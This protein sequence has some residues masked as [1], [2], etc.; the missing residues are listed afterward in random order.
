MDPLLNTAP[1]AFVSFADDGT[2]VEVNQTLADLLGY[3]RFE[4]EGWH[5]DKLL[6]PGGR[7]F[8]HTYLFPMLKMHALVEEIYIAFRT[9]GGEDVPMLLNAVRRE[10]DGRL[11]NDCIA[12]RMIQRHEYEQ[13]LLDAR[14]L[15]EES[16]D[17]KAKFLSMM[18]HDLRTPLTT[19]QGNANLLKGDVFGA[20]NDEQRNAVD[21]IRDA[22]RLQMTMVSDI[23]DYARADAGRLEMHIREVRLS[24]VSARAVT[25]VRTQV[26]DAQLRLTTTGCTEDVLVLADDDRL[27]Q[28]LLNL[29]TNAVKF[30]PPGG[31]IAIGCEIR[32][33]RACIHVRDTGIGIDPKQLQ[34]IFSPFVQLGT[35]VADAPSATI[36]VG[37]GLA[38]SR[39]L[40]RAM[41]GDV[42][43]ESRQGE[44]SVFTIELPAASV[45]ARR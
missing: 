30:T 12:V 23:L 22:C 27:Q 36:G 37:L 43:V 26:A 34:R 15:A 39:D 14:R 41:G 4:L 24:D 20:L 17:A 35:P 42:T 45:L 1:C 8:Y 19:I 40:A 13:Q 9:K 44:G 28:I 10:R 6:P 5:V 11:F 32:E 38:I 3:T 25:L 31:D 18:S 33:G 16:N 2:V 21:V 7:I 29:I